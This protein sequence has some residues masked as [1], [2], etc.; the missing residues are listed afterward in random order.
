MGRYIYYLDSYGEINVLDTVTNSAKYINEMDQW[1]SFKS[2]QFFDSHRER[3]VC[4][5][6]GEFDS[7]DNPV[8]VLYGD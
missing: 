4:T 6:L 3:D 7:L 1:Y 8:E 2:K 5:Q